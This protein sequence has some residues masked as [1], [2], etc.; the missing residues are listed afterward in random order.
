[1]AT[2]TPGAVI[3]VNAPFN[4]NPAYSGTF[5]PT[6]WSKK[7]N[8]KFYASTMLSEVSN[9]N[10][11]GEIQNQGD[12]IR[13][14]TAPSITIRDYAG[15]GSVLDSEVPTPIFTDMQIDQAKYFSVQVSDVLEYQADLEL[16]SMFTEDAGKQLK[17]AIE[18]NTFYNWFV[19]N[20]PHASNEGATAGAISGGFNL[21]TDTAPIDQADP[22]NVL[23]AILE[24]AAVLD[25]Q[26][27][28]EEGRWLM[29]SP[30]DR[31][32]LMQSNIA[33]AYFTGD[34]S[35]TVRSGKIGMLDRFT[36][37]VSNLLP[38]GAAGTDWND[39]QG[40]LTPGAVA[41]AKARRMM[42]AGTKH[43]CS[44][45][46]QITKTEPLR[47]QSDFGDIVRGLSVFGRKVTKPEALTVAVVGSAV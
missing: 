15:P 47:N 21:G 12:T 39:G 40:T 43:A 19:T 7:L 25:E 22:Q 26:N 16:M 9:T 38:R 27:V 31:N 29:L 1:M 20:G 34:S 42:V 10:W 35:S 8:A 13:I 33:Q 4:T 45:A 3:P 11:E 41:G 23:N 18:N 28:P 32:L 36:V 37:F 5:I 44:F 6:L 24:M 14:R 17:I 46:S 30:K 2:V